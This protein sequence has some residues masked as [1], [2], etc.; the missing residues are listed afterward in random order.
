MGQFPGLSDT[1]CGCIEHWYLCFFAPAPYDGGSDST[2]GRCQR[3]QVT[4]PAARTTSATIA[5]TRLAMGLSLRQRLADRSLQIGP[6]RLVF[7]GSLDV[8]EVDGLER[9]Q[10]VEQ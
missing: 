1:I 9:A 4:P 10:G 3:H 2:A 7:G 8:L 5:S 6:R